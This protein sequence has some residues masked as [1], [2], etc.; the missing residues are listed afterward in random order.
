MEVI[1]YRTR[2]YDISIYELY[3]EEIEALELGFKAG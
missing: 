3:G 1:V 2:P